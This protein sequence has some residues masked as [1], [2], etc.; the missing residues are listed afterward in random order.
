MTSIRLKRDT[1]VKDLKRLESVAEKGKIDAESLAKELDSIQQQ[2]TDKSEQAV[3][4]QETCDEAAKFSLGKQARLAEIHEELEG[5][6]SMVNEMRDKRADVE[7]KVGK[8]QA[9][10]GEE[11]RKEK[12]WLQKISEL[13]INKLEYVR[14]HFVLTCT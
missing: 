4:I 11:Q 12:H 10:L 14:V 2:L 7:I 13:K 9:T 6:Q 5:L 1:C 3:V 8:L